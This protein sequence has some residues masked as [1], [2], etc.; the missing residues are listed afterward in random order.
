MEK[1]TAFALLFASLLLFGCTLN[2]PQIIK[3]DTLTPIS[4]QT[5]RD[6][7]DPNVIIRIPNA[8]QNLTPPPITPP[9]Q[10]PNA[11][12]AT[13]ISSN[14]TPPNASIGSDLRIEPTPFADLEAYFISSGGGDAIFLRKGSFTMLIDAGA[15][16]AS[17]ELVS[18]LRSLGVTRL[19]VVAVSSPTDDNTGGMPAILS[20][21]PV[22]EYWDNGVEPREL[23][24]TRLYPALKAALGQKGL[25]PKKPQLGSRLSVNGLEIKVL[26]P[27]PARYRSFPNTDSLVLKVT[28]NQYCMMLMG[29][30]YTSSEST[31]AAMGS[32]V[33]CDLLKIS[34]HASG[35]ATGDLLLI[36]VNPEYAIVIEGASAPNPTILERMRLK[37]INVTRVAPGETAIA[38][39][40]AFSP[41]VITKE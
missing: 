33:R 22:T 39:N 7:Y 34:D 28:N 18:K 35:F 21:F 11:T 8:S 6:P 5:P 2:P 40:D 37:G 17:Q 31:I 26:N 13:N 20:S 23:P 25:T 38:T 27:Q 36:T 4:S 29:N 9:I 14:A 30:S 3:N 16:S 41:F 1:A 10:P 32:D 12:N 19:E 24:T 15:E